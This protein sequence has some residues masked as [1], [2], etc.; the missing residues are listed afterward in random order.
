MNFLLPGK[1]DNENSETPTNWWRD[2]QNWQNATTFCEINCWIDPQHKVPDISTHSLIF[3]FSIFWVDLLSV[4]IFTNWFAPV[5]YFCSAII[6]KLTSETEE[7]RKHGTRQRNR[8]NKPS[9]CAPL[10]KCATPFF[11][12]GISGG[13]WSH[14]STSFFLALLPW[15]IHVV[16]RTRRKKAVNPDLFHFPSF[17]TF[18]CLSF[19]CTYLGQN[20]RNI[21]E[22]DERQHQH[23]YVPLRICSQLKEHIVNYMQNVT[24]GRMVIFMDIWST[25]HQSWW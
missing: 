17:T 16:P 25:V 4:L 7:I 13:N 19:G 1:R 6:K 11:Y 12:V 15:D 14:A 2:S 23:F 10:L 9:I 3:T 18:A 22:M 5:M 21:S 8:T 20:L 24:G